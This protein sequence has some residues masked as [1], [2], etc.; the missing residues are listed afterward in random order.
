MPWE[1]N[2]VNA[3]CETPPDYMRNKHEDWQKAW[4]LRS[5]LDQ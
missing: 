3:V 1:T 5:E 4:A 2:P